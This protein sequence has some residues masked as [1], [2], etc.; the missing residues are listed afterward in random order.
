MS[1]IGILLCHANLAGELLKTTE[2]IL[3]YTESL[4]SFSNDR[5]TPEL[6][7]EEVGRFVREKA[8]DEVVVLVDLRGG[9]CWKV[10]C[11]L[12]QEFSQI[13]VLSGVNLPMIVSFITKFRTQPF[14]KFV[15]IIEQDAHR[16]IVLDKP[17]N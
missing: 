2:K 17:G 5:I 12:W 14:E 3:G 9:N 8:A 11:R 7:F 4:Y 10:G 13:R 15:E 1:R 6:L 16:G